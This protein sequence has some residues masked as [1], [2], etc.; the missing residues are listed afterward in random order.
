VSPK[1]PRR[2]PPRPVERLTRPLQRF[3]HIQALGGVVL[4]CATVF[5][6]ALA[7]SAWAADYSA[8]WNKT[9][10]IRIGPLALSYPLYYWVN[11]GLMVIFFFLIGLEIKR[12]L[13]WG[14]LRDRRNVVLPA[15]AAIGGAAIPVGL[16]LIL[17][18]QAPTRDGWAVPMATDIAFVV[19]CLAI[20][21]NRVPPA[22]KVFMLSLAILDDIL[23]VL[24]IA[25]FF[26]SEVSM[27]WLGGAAAGFGLI[28]LLNRVGVREVGIYLIVGAVIW[29]CTLKSG[30]HPT[31]AGA[32]LGLLTPASAWIG[33]STL[34]DVVSHAAER[35]RG[36]EAVPEAERRAAAEDISFAATESVAPLER[37]EHALHPWVSFVIMPIFALANAGVI[38]SM[39]G[40]KDS[41]ALAI[42]VG[43]VVGKPVGILIA[44][45]LAVRS[46]RARLPDGVSWPVVVGSGCLAGI[47]FTM[48][49]FIASLSLEG[50][51]LEAAKAG[52]L[53]ASAVSMLLGMTILARALRRE[54]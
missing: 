4:L 33:T 21:G 32:L 53:I 7:N 40:M 22:L 35:L 18:Q 9:F 27:L 46:G 28:Y 43:L 50:S 42:I 20:L 14:E 44:S 2:I 16:F 1:K 25:V 39:D 34:L 36:G 12:E 8:F 47:G 30:V 15:A 13:V 29:L 23:A 31:V 24:I 17:Q 5:A 51:S 54:D 3:L 6:L 49:L 45:W 10:E 38:V 19:G 48:A 11:D 26:T 37:L 41:I 52:I